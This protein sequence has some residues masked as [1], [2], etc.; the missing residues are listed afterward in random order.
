LEHKPMLE[1]SDL[2]AYYGHIQALKGVSIRVDEGEI[3]TVI[4]A[5]GAGKS[6]LL[7]SIAGVI[8]K[9]KGR[10]AFQGKDIL[11]FAPERIVSHGISLVPEGRQIFSELSVI[12]NLEMGGYLLLKKRRREEFKENIESAFHLFPVLKDRM[13]QIA[14]T[15]S[16]GEQQMLAISRALMT[17][18]K[19][20]MLDEPS[21]GLAPKVIR[22]I[23]DTL[24]TLNKQG[25]TIL[26][27]EQDAKIALSI[28]SRGYVFQTGQVVIEEKASKL[29]DDPTVKEIYFG[30]KI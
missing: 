21:M 10:V 18:P 12:D 14:G 24:H 9:T 7:N 4:G 19:L 1:V 11:S 13:D 15:L 6:T 20:I 17:R 26:L 16:G 23:F 25:M 2:S 27:V 5:N 29:I 28:A 22:S 8:G 30:K 3:V